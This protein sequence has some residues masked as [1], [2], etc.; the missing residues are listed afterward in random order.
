MDWSQSK[1]LMETPLLTGRIIVLKC[2]A[3]VLLFSL[4]A[5][6]LCGKQTQDLFSFP[7]DST[8]SFRVRIFPFTNMPKIPIQREVKAPRETSRL[9][10]CAQTHRLPEN[11][12][13]QD[14]S[15]SSAVICW[16]SFAALSCLVQKSLRKLMA[17][18]DTWRRCSHWTSRK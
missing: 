16:F 17:Y 8:W 11:E 9:K 12:N 18:Q 7:Q 13:Y 2:W 1:V 3:Q 6:Y 14:F 4:R 5:S 15:S 10:P